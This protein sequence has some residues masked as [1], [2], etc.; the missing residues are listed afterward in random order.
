MR[1]YLQDVAFQRFVLGQANPHWRIRSF[2]MLADTAK[3]ATVSGLNQCFR[4][5]RGPAVRQ[6]VLVQEGTTPDTI[7]EPILTAVCVDGFVD[8]LLAG[9]LQAPGIGGAFADVVMLWAQHYGADRKLPPVIGSHCAKCEFRAEAGEPLASGF[10]ECWQDA[11]GLSR[12]EV[13]AGT[14]LDIWNLPKK[15]DVLIGQGVL[16]LSEVTRD[17]LAYKESGE[18]LTHSQRHWMQVSGQR[19]SPSRTKRS[20]S[21]CDTTCASSSTPFAFQRCPR[22]PGC[23]LSSGTRRRLGQDVHRTRCGLCTRRRY[24]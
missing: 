23:G 19:P 5:R 17:H 3:V 6:R 13:D 14:V 18:G 8:E 11:K 15:K 22:L 7:G 24:R 20:P 4:I 10:H 1:P 12:E 2:L 21:N 16:R 9:S